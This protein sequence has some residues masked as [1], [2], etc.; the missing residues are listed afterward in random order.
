MNT[1]NAYLKNHNI[2]AVIS[3]KR[4]NKGFSLIE[5][6]IVVKV[7]AILAAIAIPAYTDIS[8]EARAS[9]AMSTLANLVKECAVKLASTGSTSY[10]TPT[11]SGY[12]IQ[13]ITGIGGT[14][15]ESKTYTANAATGTPTGN[16]TIV[17]ATGEKNAPG[18]T[19][20]DAVP[21]LRN[22]VILIYLNPFTI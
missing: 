7:L 3:R 4:G 15:S 17:A 20:L 12:T 16:F 11:L 14:C 8:N 21:R 19:V 1:L 18:A 22:M 6:V 13:Q 9:G 2:R 5:L 10:V